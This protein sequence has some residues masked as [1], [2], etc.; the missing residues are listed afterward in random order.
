MITSVVR[1]RTDVSCVEDLRGMSMFSH[2]C[3][4]SSAIHAI[5]STSG[6]V[7]VCSTSKRLGLTDEQTHVDAWPLVRPSFLI[8][9]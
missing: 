6:D 8:V 4:H 9:H 3:A 2:L 5:K 7:T 1:Q